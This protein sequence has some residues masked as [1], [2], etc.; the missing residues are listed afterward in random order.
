MKINVIDKSGDKIAEIEIDTRDD[1]SSLASKIARS[2]GKRPEHITDLRII[3]GP[4]IDHL[5]MS[6]AVEVAF[7]PGS[8]G[9]RRKGSRKSRKTRKTS[10]KNRR[11][12]RRNRRNNY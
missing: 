10:R 3:G 12:T 6:R 11:N 5:M 4:D 9:R 8:G 2:V 7:K 1:M